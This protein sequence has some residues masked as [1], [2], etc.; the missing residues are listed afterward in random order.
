VISI[1]EIL[2]ISIFGFLFDFGL[3][4]RLLDDVSK[5][6]TAPCWPVLVQGSGEL[7]LLQVKKLKKAKVEEDDGWWLCRNEGLISTPLLSVKHHDQLNSRK[8]TF[9]RCD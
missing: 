8:H 3:A 1:D 6:G 2:T 5:N 4:F 7:S 9:I